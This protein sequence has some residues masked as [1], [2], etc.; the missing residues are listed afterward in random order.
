MM[1]KLPKHPPFLHL[2]CLF[3]CVYHLSIWRLDH[4]L[5]S[6]CWRG[7]QVSAVNQN[8]SRHHLQKEENKTKDVDI[9]PMLLFSFL[10]TAKVAD[11]LAWTVPNSREGLKKKTI[12]TITGKGWRSVICDQAAE[13]HEQPYSCLQSSRLIIITGQDS[14]SGWKL[15]NWCR[16]EESAFPDEFGAEL[17]FWQQH[18]RQTD[19]GEHH[20]DDQQGDP[21]ALP[22]PV[23]PDGSNVLNSREKKSW[24]TGA[25][26]VAAALKRWRKS[27]Q[28][29]HHRRHVSCLSVWHLTSNREDSC[30][31][32]NC[33]C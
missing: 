28:Q 22:V 27:Q 26:E 2:W 5:G 10:N 19:E 21:D 33:N 12:P 15:T 20:Q 1:S 17:A 18:N 13:G 11:F 23:R 9:I 6:F 4:A 16:A 24:I 32:S 29:K 31:R 25:E 30:L 3:S 14:S 8:V 7:H